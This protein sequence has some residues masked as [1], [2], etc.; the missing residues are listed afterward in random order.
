MIAM[1]ARATIGGGSRSL[2]PNTG[3]A[4]KNVNIDDPVEVELAG[5]LHM[6]TFQ[7][8]PGLLPVHM[9]VLGIRLIFGAVL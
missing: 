1:P 2:H 6:S 5:R 4:G 3:W 8:L 9:L 7:I